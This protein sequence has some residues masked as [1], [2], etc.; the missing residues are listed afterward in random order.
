MRVP[1]Q[2]QVYELIWVE[3]YSSQNLYVEALTPST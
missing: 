3:W 1:N 2:G